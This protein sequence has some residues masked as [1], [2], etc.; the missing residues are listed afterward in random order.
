MNLFYWNLVEIIGIGFSSLRTFGKA[1]KLSR[2]Q[3]CLTI[4]MYNRYLISYGNDFTSFCFLFF[5]FS[6]TLFRFLFIS[7]LYLFFFF[8][9]ICCLMIMLCPVFGIIFIRMYKLNVHVFLFYLLICFSFLLRISNLFALLLYSPF[10]S[11]FNSMKLMTMMDFYD[12]LTWQS[13]TGHC[14]H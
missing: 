3:H 4:S 5:S 8:L 11:L 12:G 14:E 7:H 6:V 1:F 10:V 13:H 2:C 9:P